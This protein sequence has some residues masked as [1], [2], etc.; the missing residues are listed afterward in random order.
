MT[1]VLRSQ[2]TCKAQVKLKGNGSQNLLLMIPSRER[3]D[4][5]EHH[6]QLRKDKA[7]AQPS[8]VGFASH[9]EL[10][11]GAGKLAQMMSEH[12]HL[13]AAGAHVVLLVTARNN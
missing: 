10:E 9:L 7:I 5:I 3:C 13:D 2:E 6:T 4:Y 11:W 8:H 12:T 1:S